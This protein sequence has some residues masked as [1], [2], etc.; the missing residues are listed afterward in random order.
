MANDLSSS[1]SSYGWYHRS[2]YSVSSSCHPDSLA[3]VVGFNS[4]ICRQTYDEQ[5]HPIG[6]LMYRYDES[7]NLIYAAEY[8]DLKCREPHTRWVKGLRRFAEVETEM[9]LTECESIE[10]DDKP[11][12]LPDGEFYRKSASRSV[13]DQ[14][15][16]SRAY[17]C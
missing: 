17:N 4:G 6:S 5:R 3:Y 1:S 15:C 13:S 12:G 7:N 10:E 14:T 16:Y 11:Y 8:V 2:Y 9:H